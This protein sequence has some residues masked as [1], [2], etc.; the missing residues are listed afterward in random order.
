MVSHLRIKKGAVKKPPKK[1]GP[2]VQK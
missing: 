1:E 2:K